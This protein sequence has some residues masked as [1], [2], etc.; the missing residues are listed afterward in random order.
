MGCMGIEIVLHQ[1]DGHALFG[2]GQDLKALGF[3]LGPIDTE[4]LHKR[5]DLIEQG[6]DLRGVIL[7]D[8]GQDLRDDFAYG[9]IVRKGG[10]F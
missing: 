10:F 2:A 7:S 3:I 1:A 4:G 9:F 6:H 5:W 8:Q